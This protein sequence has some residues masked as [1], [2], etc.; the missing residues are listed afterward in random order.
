MNKTKTL[1]NGIGNLY[2]TEKYYDRW[3]Q[4]YETTLIKWRYTVPKKAINILN[5]KVKYEPKKIYD[6]ACGTGLFGEKLI[7]AYKKSIIYGSDIS[8][9]SLLIASKKKIYKNLKKANFNKIQYFKTKFDLVSIIG[10][11][12]YCKNPNKLFSNIKFY[13]KKKGYF[14]FS[15]RLD[16]WEKQGFDNLLISHENDLEVIYISKPCNYLPLNMD[17]KNKNNL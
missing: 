17:Y 11:M 16:M 4:T 3:S 9:K 6:L 2:D 12:T 1:V 14:I 8:K 15:H 7:K 10:A 5:N 13:L